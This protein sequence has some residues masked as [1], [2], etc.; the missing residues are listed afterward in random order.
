VW[1]GTPFDV[2]WALDVVRGAIRTPGTSV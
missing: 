2:A 1:D